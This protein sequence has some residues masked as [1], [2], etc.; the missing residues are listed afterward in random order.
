MGN[1]VT[2]KIEKLLNNFGTMFNQTSSEVPSN[3]NYL[4]KG[5]FADINRLLKPAESM[6][7]SIKASTLGNIA[8]TA[9]TPAKTIKPFVR[10]IKTNKYTDKHPLLEKLK[11]PNDEQEYTDF[12]YEVCFQKLFTNNVFLEKIGTNNTFEIYPVKPKFIEVFGSAKELNYM[13]NASEYYKFLDS[14]FG[15]KN[16]IFKSTYS[17]FKTLYHFKGM[18]DDEGYYGLSP[19]NSILRELELSN[20]INDY[21]ISLLG[22]GA[23][24]SG[25][26]TLDSNNPDDLKRLKHDTENNFSGTR[27]AGKFLVTLGKSV[28]FK[29]FGATNKEM[30]FGEFLDKSEQKIYMEF[31]IPLPLI[32]QDTQTY[33]NYETANY[34][35][36][37][38]VVLPLLND[39]FEYLSTLYRDVG[40]LEKDEQLCYNPEDI[41]ILKLESLESIKVL[42]GV[43]E[44]NELRKKVGLIEKPNY[45]KLLVG[46]NQI[47]IKDLDK[48]ETSQNNTDVSQNKNPPKKVEKE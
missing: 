40:L 27:N 11:E 42:E 14:N 4:I 7:M 24:L 44:I 35:L 38:C 20:A 19:L 5:K 15:G 6:E 34:I 28:D 22:N 16:G 2:Q 31:D 43:A 32:K 9:L 48:I 46:R 3:L 23:N 1:Y 8:S 10:N 30:A 12:I 36:H 41:Q 17:S 37:I 26:F 45:N 25:V 21:N 47:D 29:P 33:N 39:V 18:T 13:I